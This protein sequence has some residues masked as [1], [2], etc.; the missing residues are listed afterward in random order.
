M[1]SFD[2]SPEQQPQYLFDRITT[3]MEDRTIVKGLQ[4]F[5]S[6]AS[7]SDPSSTPTPA[8]PPPQENEDGDEVEVE[9]EE[10]ATVISAKMLES[11][12][13]A[14]SRKCSWGCC[15]CTWATFFDD[16]QEATGYAIVR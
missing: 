15:C 11:E 9:E 16:N 1:S 14:P 3:T 2:S 10:E 13:G 4:P 8:L 7:T 5:M 6:E 12:N